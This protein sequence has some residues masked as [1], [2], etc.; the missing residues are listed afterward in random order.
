ME[1][2]HES[3]GDYIYSNVWLTNLILKINLSTNQVEKTFDATKL[4]NNTKDSPGGSRIDVLNG[5]AYDHLTDTFLLT[6]KKWPLF[7]V[8]K[9]DHP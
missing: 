2:V 8:S 1:W 6:G 9:L 3:D 4:V 7:Y 5:I